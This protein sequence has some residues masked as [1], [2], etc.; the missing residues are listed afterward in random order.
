MQLRL[1]EAGTDHF[2]GAAADFQRREQQGDYHR[3]RPPGKSPQG[4]AFAP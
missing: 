4:P 2:E 1:G 3:G